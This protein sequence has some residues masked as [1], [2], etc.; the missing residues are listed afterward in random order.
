MICACVS[1]R[2]R[3]AWSPRNR[4]RISTFDPT[5][6][7]TEIHGRPYPARA[8]RRARCAEYR[9]GPRPGA[10]KR[11]RWPPSRNR[12]RC[13][14]LPSRKC[15]RRWAICIRSA[16]ERRPNSTTRRVAT[17][18]GAA[19]GRSGSSARTLTTT[20]STGYRS[21]GGRAKKRR[22]VRSI[23]GCGLTGAARSVSSVRGAPSRV[24]TKKSQT[25][26]ARRAGRGSNER[27]AAAIAELTR[28]GDIVQTVRDSA[29]FS[30]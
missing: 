16:V 8:P 9:T 10:G 28:S 13:T 3:L 15:C 4:S 26:P 23:P 22:E 19:R 17:G 25:R 2:H 1:A 14:T 7:T 12:S 30:V 24:S 27:I 18:R 11:P 6:F 5:R 20:G 21:L 29:R